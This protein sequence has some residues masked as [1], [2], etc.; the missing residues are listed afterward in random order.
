MMTLQDME[1]AARLDII[2]AY[3]PIDELLSE[4][5]DSKAVAKYYRKSDFF[6]NHVLSHGGN[7]IHM[8]LSD[9]QFYHKDD[10]LKQAQF[11]GE[12]ISGE[13]MHILEVGAGKLANTKYLAKTFPNHHFTALDLPNRKF[14]KNRVPK[15]VTLVEGNYHDLSCFEENTFDIAFG[16]E[17][18]CY[19]ET[20]EKVAEQMARVLKLGGKFIIFD[21]YECKPHEEMTDFEK[22]VS[23]VAYAG[24]RVTS[25]DQYIGDMLS[26]LKKHGFTTIDH[27]D[28]SQSIR[29]TLRKLDCVAGYYFMHP[30]LLK[31]LR[32]I[33]PYEAGING[34]AGWLMLMSID[35][36][37]HLYS[38]I[39]A[40]KG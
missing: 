20:K 17:T 27:T 29:P 3:Y 16:V 26:Y 1:L 22:R 28:I 8:G 10:F 19:S 33:I 25:K 30:R 5:T 36:Q 35:G 12:H 34:I 6:Y 39:V 18:I 32:K 31:F 9:D 24:M 11:V 38:R 15:N 23:A 21:G 2:D 40:T 13:G 37:H 4:K 14:L 7:F